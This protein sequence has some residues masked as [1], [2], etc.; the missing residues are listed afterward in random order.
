MTGDVD[1]DRCSREAA[2]IL[3][4]GYATKA[5][6]VQRPCA[7]AV[8]TI[9]P[10]IDATSPIVR[11][12]GLVTASRQRGEMIEIPANCPALPTVLQ[13]RSEP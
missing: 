1:S 8:Q 13:S 7:G 5:P 4:A 9:A 2:P 3:V 6:A 11:L 12:R 10:S